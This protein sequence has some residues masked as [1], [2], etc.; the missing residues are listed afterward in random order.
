MPGSS[1]KQ[2][3]RQPAPAPPPPQQQAMEMHQLHHQGQYR[4]PAPP[5]PHLQQQYPAPPPQ[6][7][8]GTW[9]GGQGYQ[10]PPPHHQQQYPQAHPGAG[11]YPYPPPPQAQPYH[12]QAQ[13]YHPQAAYPYPPPQGPQQGSVVPYT[14]QQ[15]P[16]A[17]QQQ[18]RKTSGGGGNQQKQR[19]TSG[20]GTQRPPPQRQGS[21]PTVHQQQPTRQSSRKV[22]S[23]GEQILAEGNPSRSSLVCDGI[24][25]YLLMGLYM[26]IGGLALFFILIPLGICCGL[27]ATKDWRLYFTRNGI[28]HVR[29]TGS[30]CSCCYDTWFFAL[31]DI[32]NIT[33]IVGQKTILIE[34]VDPAKVNDY[35]H[36]CNRPMCRTTTGILIQHVANSE[37]FV[38]A[39]RQHMGLK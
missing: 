13:P 29:T 26:F 33:Y 31:S 25:F 19:K 12:P 6:Q 21:H 22:D 39:V 20:G 38:V 30:G 23:H 2:Q 24:N 3:Y 8:M 35:I 36:W 37:E 4:Q 17:M 5:P 34:F 28:Y 11:A 27:R 32:R 18:Q 16:A 15:H 10:H 9:P 7:Y 14:Q 1:R